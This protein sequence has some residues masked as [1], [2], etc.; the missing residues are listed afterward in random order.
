MAIRKI[1]NVKYLIEKEGSMKVDAIVFANEKIFEKI[2]EDKSLEQLKNV[3]SLPGIVGK[4]I[5][6]PDIHWGYGMPVGGVAAFDA[7]DGIIG[8][9]MIGFDIN[10]GVRLHITSLLFEDIK[11]KIDKIVKK[12]FELI[13]AGVGLSGHVELG[14]K[15]MKN[16]CEEGAKFVVEKL[17]FGSPDELENIESYGCIEGADFS[18]V[19]EKAYERGR[20]QLGTVGSGNHFVELGYVEKVFRKDI[21]EKWGVFEGQVTLLVHSGSR[22]FGHQICEDYLKVALRW[23]EKNRAP[24]PDKQL[25]YMG[26]NSSEAKSY[27]S[28]MKSAINYAFSNRLIIAHYAKKALADALGIKA[29]RLG[30]KLIYDVAHNTAKFEEHIVDGKVRKVVVHRKGATRAFP[31][32]HPELPGKHREI[33]Q[34]V[35]IPGDMGRYSYLLVGS[36]KSMEESFGSTCH[37]AGRVMSRKQAIKSARGRD[38]RDELLR[39]NIFV[40]AREV[41]LLAE[42]MSDAYKD[43]ADVVEVCEEAGLSLIVARLK[44]VGVIKG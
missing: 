28:A 17:G 22:G 27:I 13:P 5:G 3:A 15:E 16:V 6:M 43:V 42:E 30:W 7:E 8:P 2:V 36:E 20:D 31:K 23:C 18:S 10:C 39:K 44:P 9:G 35:I 11:D 14:K 4:A 29:E 37:G 25:A 38:I 24:L 34:P 26:I 1:N 19:S 41:H 21:A 32:G 12:M 33:G 40:M